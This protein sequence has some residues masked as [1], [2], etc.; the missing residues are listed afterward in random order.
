MN[1]RQGLVTLTAAMIL[2]SVSLLGTPAVAAVSHGDVQAPGRTLAQQATRNQAP[3]STTDHGKLKPLQK[4]FTSGN[5]ITEAC[6][7]CHSEADAQFR[8]TI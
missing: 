7:S 1:E 3:W 5:Q 2:L 4:V 8:Q 6:L